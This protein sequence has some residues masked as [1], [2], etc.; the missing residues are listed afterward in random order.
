MRV[1]LND[2]FAAA[3]EPDG[4]EMRDGR[5]GSETGHG[6]AAPLAAVNGWSQTG[7]G[8]IKLELQGCGPVRITARRPGSPAR[9]DFAPLPKPGRPVP[10]GAEMVAFRATLL[11]HAAVL[12]GLPHAPFGRDR[13]A[14]LDDAGRITCGALHHLALPAGIRSKGAASPAA[15][16]TPM[17]RA[18]PVPGH[19]QAWPGRFPASTARRHDRIK[20]AADELRTG[21]RD[22][23]GRLR[24][25]TGR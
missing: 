23:R 6:T 19:G 17:L 24:A 4:R 3:Q 11:R 9:A 5:V 13:L 12:P 10:R 21:A 22:A 14:S 7:S 2:A 1:A 16:R 20:H 25:G 15:Q 18:V 8:P